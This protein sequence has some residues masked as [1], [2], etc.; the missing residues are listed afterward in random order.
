[1]RTLHHRDCIQPISHVNKTRNIWPLSF[2]KKVIG[3]SLTSYS[4]GSDS[5]GT[6]C[7]ILQNSFHSEEWLL[8]LIGDQLTTL[9]LS[10]DCVDTIQGCKMFLSLKCNCCYVLHLHRSRPHS[11]S[12]HFH[13]FLHLNLAISLRGGH[14][15]LYSLQLRKLRSGSALR[16]T[17]HSW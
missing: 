17:P 10:V 13:T 9:P 6:G 16:P 7:R 3:G 15:G 12:W 14:A 5:L 2:F 1:M 8:V 4:S 11:W